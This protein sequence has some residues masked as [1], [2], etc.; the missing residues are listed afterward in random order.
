[1]CPF[2]SCL[3]KIATCGMRKIHL[4]AGAL[5]LLLSACEK[6]L[7]PFEVLEE[8]PGTKGKTS[9]VTVDFRS[10]EMIYPCFEM[11]GYIGGLDSSM[12]AY[13]LKISVTDAAG[14]VL[15]HDFGAQVPDPII[16]A[17][18]H[19]LWDK[20]EPDSAT[21]ARKARPYLKKRPLTWYIDAG[22]AP[23]TFKVLIPYP[24]VSKAA[25]D[26]PMEVYVRIEGFFGERES[27][28][29]TDPFAPDPDPKGAKADL[30]TR[31]IVRYPQ[32]E[33]RETEIRV[34][35][36][37][38]NTATYGPRKWDFT[39][40]GDGNVGYPDLMWSIEADQ[41][42]VWESPYHFKNGTEG[43]FT[44]TVARFWLAGKDPQVTVCFM[45]WD[46]ETV[47]NNQHDE[48]GCWEGKLADLS[49]NPLKPTVLK[50]GNIKWADVVVK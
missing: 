4:L 2:A 47:F 35:K 28:Y 5:V 10:R 1:M 38:V 30:L 27:W 50:F 43:D 46:N 18:G 14:K 48:I 42:P 15:E 34:G 37:E 22:I 40:S 41:F 36:V 20:F 17:E 6:H 31:M 39:L 32:P 9:N 11:S 23:G 45:D 12:G 26:T 7:K 16:P 24:L 19:N 21:V 3:E 49:K 25:A 8:K 29:P 33:L 44:G 13:Y